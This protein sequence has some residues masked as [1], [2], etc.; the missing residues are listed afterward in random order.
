MIVA[1]GHEVCAH[2]YRWL[3]EFSFEKNA[4]APSSAKPSRHRPPRFTERTRRLLV[5]EGFSITWTI[6]PMTFR[7]GNRSRWPGCRRIVVVLYA[8]DTNDLKFWLAPGYAPAQWLDSHV[9]DDCSH[10]AL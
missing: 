4:S 3:H 6:I 5:K 2:G 8:L 7:A 1:G 10:V 9:F